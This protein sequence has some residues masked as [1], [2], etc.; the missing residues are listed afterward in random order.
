MNNI[1]S[2]WG[3]VPKVDRRSFVYTEYQLF[4]TC[5][6]HVRDMGLS[7]SWI[8]EVPTPSAALDSQ[9]FSQRFSFALVSTHYKFSV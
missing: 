6:R 8:T 7:W 3:D 1:L 2:I 4:E 5:A 9:V